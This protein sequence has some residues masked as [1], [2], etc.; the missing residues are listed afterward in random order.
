MK[1]S[2]K[3]NDIKFG[4]GLYFLGKAQKE[5]GTDLQGLLNSIS[6][7]PISDVVDLMWLSA[8]LEAEL[9]D[10]KLP[11]SKRDF[12]TYLEET[13][14]FDN[15]NGNVSNWV[16]GFMDTI[17]DNFLPKEDAQEETEEADTKKK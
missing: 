8:K 2:I 15:D 11:I 13:K 7:N 1:L 10:V 9:D 17:K 14:D 16:K 6:K 5:L 4:Y 12:V 3:G